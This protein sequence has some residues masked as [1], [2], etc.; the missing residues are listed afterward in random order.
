[1]GLRRISPCL[2]IRTSRSPRQA[3]LRISPIVNGQS[4]ASVT[5]NFALT[6][7][8]PGDYVIPAFERRGRGPEGQ[9]RAAGAQS[10]RAVCPPPEA[11]NSGAQL[12]FLK[13][14]LPKKQVYVGE[15]FVARLELYLSSRCKTSRVHNSPRFRRKVQHRQSSPGPAAIGPGWERC[16]YCDSSRSAAQDRSLRPINGRSG[17]LQPGARNARGEPRARPIRSLWLFP[18]AGEQK[19]VSVATEAETVQSLP[20]PSESVPA[21]STARSARTRCPSPPGRPTSRRRPHHHPNSNLRR[22]SPDALVLPEQPAWH[23]FKVL[24]PTTKFEG[25]DQLG[26]QGT[27]TFEQIVTPQNADIK[28]LPPIAFSFFDPDQKAYRTLTQPGVPLLVRP[29]GS[30]PAPTV[31]AANRPG[32]DSPP[33][34]QG[35]LPNK[36][37][38]G[39]LAQLGPPLVQ[40]T[41]FLALQGLPLLVFLSALVWRRRAES[42]AHNPRLRRQRKVARVIRQ[43]LIDLR[44]LAGENQPDAFFETLSRLLQEQIGERLD[45]PS[46]AI[47]EAVIEEHLRPRGVPESTLTLLQGLFQTCNLVRYAP[48]KTSQELAALIPKLEQA[49][50]NCRR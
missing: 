39:T 30:T 35:I 41:W 17:H 2:R 8:Q 23:D 40:R 21:A 34:A 10:P 32:A 14:V 38:L 24:P 25:A 49:L 36:Q 45:L 3:N 4:S 47:T 1:V 33:P 37:R 50:R 9:F 18:R 31:L 15:T 6:P 46:S 16:L 26:I 44:R 29:G 27:K 5:Y 43:G 7:R 19:Q 13:L 12:A 11:V 48:I 42:L 20:L 22:G 28:A